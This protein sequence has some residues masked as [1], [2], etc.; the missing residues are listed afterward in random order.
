MWKKVANKFIIVDPRISQ[1]EKIFIKMFL[2]KLLD[3]A[4]KQLRSEKYNGM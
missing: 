1:I 4:L 3:G 2:V